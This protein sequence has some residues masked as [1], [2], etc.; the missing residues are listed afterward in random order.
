MTA[1]TTARAALGRLRTIALATA[2]ACTTGV[3]HAGFASVV[4]DGFV[5]SAT[6][7]PGSF[8]FAPTDTMSQAWDLQ[9]LSGGATLDQ[10]ANVLPN[11]DPAN[12]T[13][14]A[15]HTNATVSSFQFTD[16]L[17]QLLSPGFVLSATADLFAD[18]VLRTALGNMFSSGSF[19]FWDSAAPGDFDGTSA[20]CSGSGSLTFTLF[21]DLIVSDEDSAYAE[22][23]VVGT[24]VPGGLFF[25]FASNTL[26]VGSKEDQFFTWSADLT[27]GNAASFSLA[28]TVVA[29]AVPEPG[30]LG[31]VSLGL[32]GLC[33]TRRRSG[34]R[35]AA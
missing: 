32:I 17:T 31:L 34:T 4:I 13:A 27:A 3:A 12:A 1:V 11:W 7:A 30:I 9:V 26:G 6:G 5:I 15:P 35:A 22:L 18:G 20:S 2:L 10:N 23:N 28:G 33:L 16:P 24:G 14:Q 21:Y 29:A 25:D 8:V 19:C